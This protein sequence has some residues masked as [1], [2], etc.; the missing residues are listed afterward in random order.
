[1]WVVGDRFVSETFP[2]LP[3]LKVVLK[4]ERRPSLYIYDYYN[5]TCH[6]ENQLSANEN[7]MARL[8][9]AVIK[10]LNEPHRMPRIILM[11]VDTD[12]LTHIKHVGFGESQVIGSAINW[13]VR[14]VENA[15]ESKQDELRKR[16]PGSL[17]TGEPKVLWV[18]TFTHPYKMHPSMISAATKFNSI[19][20]DLVQ[21]KHC[22]YTID[23]SEYFRPAQ[24]SFC[25]GGLVSHHGEEEFWSAI[26]RCIEDFDYKPPT[27]TPP[28]QAVASSATHTPD[29]RVQPQAQC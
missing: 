15:I 11:I 17:H 9:N 18:K 21:N 8:V 10:G 22:H 16:R 12:L 13:I 4:E 2:A 29:V 27:S 6:A 20:M 19:L 1:M 14:N 24:A 25:P 7:T 26:N 5:I 23:V 28:T 3:E